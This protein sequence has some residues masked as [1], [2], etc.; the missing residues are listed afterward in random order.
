MINIFQKMGDNLYIYL[1][2]KRKAYW[3]EGEYYHKLKDIY[4]L[5]KNRDQRRYKIRRVI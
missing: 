4:N 5:I 2:D 1:D 3:F